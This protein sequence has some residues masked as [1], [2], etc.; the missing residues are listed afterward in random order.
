MSTYLV[1]LSAVCGAI[2]WQIQL[3]SKNKWFKF[4]VHDMDARQNGTMCHVTLQ[5]DYQK[6]HL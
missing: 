3:V 6:K 4:I 1:I 5:D 2:C